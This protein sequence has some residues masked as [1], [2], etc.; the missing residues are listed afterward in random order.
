MAK[1]TLDVNVPQPLIQ[2]SKTE[3]ITTNTTTNITPDAGY[4]GIGQVN[5]ITNINNRTY[6]GNATVNGEYVPSANYI[7]FNKFTVNV[8]NQV[9]TLTATSN[10]VYTPQAPYIG[11]DIVNVNVPNQTL[12]LV[13]T[14]N[15]IYQPTAPYIGYN[16]V[17]VNVPQLELEDWTNKRFTSNNTYT[18]SNLMNDN[19]KDGI[20]KNSTIVIDVPT[21]LITQ[22][23]NY[24]ISSN[25]IQTIP[26]PSGYDAVDSISVNVNTTKVINCIKY[27][28]GNGNYLSYYF[29]QIN[30]YRTSITIGVKQYAIIKKYSSNNFILVWNCSSSS[31]SYSLDSNDRYAIESL[32]YKYN[33]NDLYIISLGTNFN[34]LYTYNFPSNYNNEEFT[35]VVTCPF[36]LFN[37][38][39]ST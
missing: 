17:T 10:D 26:I 11:Y 35:T 14:Q 29:S 19:T 22:I 32:N 15:D 3:T 31:I 27:P 37:N 23:S 33:Y 13:A 28:Y 18:I 30:S 7:G 25:G 4:S 34:M 8:P 2:S 24:S 12:E 6:E 20:S 21:P 16:K 38:G 1:V 39:F 36:T 5:V 9:T